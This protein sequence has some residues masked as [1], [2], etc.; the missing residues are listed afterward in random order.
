MSI[1]KLIPNVERRLSAW[2]SLQSHLGQEPRREPRLTITIS[3]QFGCEGYPLAESLEA[4]LEERTGAPWTVFDKA[5]LERVSR[6]T[7]L[8]EQLLA[9]IGEDTQILDN[10]AN[11]IPGWR[12]HSEAYELLA[13]CIVRIAQEGNAIIVGRGGAVVVQSLPNCFHFRLEAPHEHRVQSIQQRLGIGRDE[14]EVLVVKRQQGRERF[15]EK[16]LHCSL[17]DTRYYNAVFNTAK[18]P[19]ARVAQSIL[20]LI[21]LPAWRAQG[22]TAAE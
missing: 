12:T 10:L 16:F 9:H 3:R 20:Q 11:L 13:R 17:A 4:L 15:I 14:A 7:H 8:S 1:Q 19:L 21:P 5:L 22:K 2:V 6:E 18:N